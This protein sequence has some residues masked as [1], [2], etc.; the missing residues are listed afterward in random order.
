MLASILN[1]KNLFRFQVVFTLAVTVLAFWSTSHL[2]DMAIICYP[3]QIAK[4]ESS[5]ISIM[6]ESGTLRLFWHGT[7][8]EQVSDLSAAE[9]GD[10][11]EMGVRFVGRKHINFKFD[12]MHRSLEGSRFNQLGKSLGE[13]TIM[14]RLSVPQTRASDGRPDYKSV[15]IQI[16]LLLITAGLLIALVKTSGRIKRS[17]RQVHQRT[18]S[19][20]IPATQS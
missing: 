5:S 15:D 1:R 19:F 2:I 8:P 4:Y 17:W 10:L 14:W 13:L 7:E 12:E 9:I 20:S 3:R 18:D 16:P 11:N 6:V